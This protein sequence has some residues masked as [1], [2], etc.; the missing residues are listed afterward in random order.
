MKDDLVGGLGWSGQVAG[1]GFNGEASYF[2]DLDNFWDTTGVLVGSAGANYTLRNGLY[3]HG[4]YLFN[5][6]G[7]KGPAGY[8][9]ALTLYLDISAK[10]FTRAKHSI[11]A[12]L[13]YP[14]TPLIRADLSAIFNPN[15]KSGFFGP[16]FDFSLTNN[17]SLF[18]IAQVFW[19]DH[20][21]EFGDYG[22]L[23][24]FR[25]KWNF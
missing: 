21:T 16:S 23:F 19:G 15:D 2:R 3:M 17:V 24:Y 12:E 9:T 14:V 5:S 25:L 8:G 11:L 13:A 22:S 1:A 10:N 7:T 6:A 4:S 18:M 20:R